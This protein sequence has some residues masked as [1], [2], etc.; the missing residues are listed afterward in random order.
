METFYKNVKIKCD[1][2][3]DFKF[4]FEY[5]GTGYSVESYNDATRVIDEIT[6]EYYAFIK[7]DVN[8]LLKKLS[9]REK[10]FVEG[11]IEELELHKCNAYCQLGICEFPFTIK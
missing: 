9:A 4:N 7:Q 11:L 8:N 3:T 5:K 6:K 1:E 10:E 2:S